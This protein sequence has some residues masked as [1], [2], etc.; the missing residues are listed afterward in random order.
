M[1][2]T[3]LIEKSYF[4]VDI[5]KKSSN[6]LKMVVK[7]KMNTDGSVIGSANNVLNIW[8]TNEMIEYLKLNDSINQVNR[9]EVIDKAKLMLA[10]FILLALG[11]NDGHFEKI[12][13]L[14]YLIR[15]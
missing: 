15:D 7:L 11:V 1:K 9:D 5:S 6:E 8:E 12:H 13:D 3:D 2:F 14:N 10:N 4:T